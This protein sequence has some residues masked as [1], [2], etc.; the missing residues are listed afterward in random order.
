MNELIDGSNN[1][2]NYL[3]RNYILIK[4]IIDGVI[5][6]QTYWGYPKKYPIFH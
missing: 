2:D 6:W 3:Y 5:C 4:K 1:T